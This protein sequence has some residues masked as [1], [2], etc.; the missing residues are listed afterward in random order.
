MTG[1]E[2]RLIIID[3]N[4]VIHRAF[5]AL[6]KLTTKRGEV[7]NAVYGFL[8]VFLRIIK[9]FQPECIVACFD[10]PGPT[11]RHK[12]FKEY[13]AK[14]PPLAE[15]LKQQIPKVK[16]VL[17]AF[18]VP[19][20]EKE[21]FEADDLIGTISGKAPTIKK[22]II[23]GDLD[24]LQLV[25]DNTKVYL[26]RKGVKDILLY[27]E[28]LV[29][30]RFRGL[31]PRQIVDFKALRGDPS[32]NIPGVSGIGEKTAIDLLKRFDNIEKLYNE[33]EKIKNFSPK[34]R[35]I[36]LK[37]KEK[38]FL[39]KDLAEIKKDVPIIFGPKECKWEGYNKR[40]V[41]KIFEDFEFYSL[42]RRLPDY[43][44]N[45]LSRNNLKLC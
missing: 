26:L 22:I 4:S 34:L 21:G 30:E 3:S 28:N 18:N 23:S 35:E 45:D 9:E 39:S 25:D 11:L 8:L 20:F 2:K 1:F 44:K 36:I 42:I 17:R 16:E 41:V 15:E 43:S 37:Q 5:H 10:T 13:K 19:I 33:L 24:N 12:K 29:K 27:D 31:Y 38:A 32:D 7:V 40:K 14:R 6:P